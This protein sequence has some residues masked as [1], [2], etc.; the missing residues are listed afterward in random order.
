MILYPITY[1]SE[2]DIL[3]VSNEYTQSIRKTCNFFDQSHSTIWE[4]IY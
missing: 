3:C 4:S 1:W 2:I